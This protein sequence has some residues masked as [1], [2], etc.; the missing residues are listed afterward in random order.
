MIL[1]A[2]WHGQ[3]EHLRAAGFVFFKITRLHTFRQV[4][5]DAL[6]KWVVELA[7]SARVAF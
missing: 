1:T 6:Y 7:I 3:V 2:L 4:N 5:V